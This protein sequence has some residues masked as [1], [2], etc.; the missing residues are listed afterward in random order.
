MRPVSE[1]HVLCRIVARDVELQR[2]RKRQGIDVC[3]LVGQVDPIAHLHVAALEGDVLLHRPHEVAH[4]SCQSKNLFDRIHQQVGCSAQR[5]C[6]FGVRSQ[7]LH[8]GRHRIRRG[9]MAR[10]RHDDVVP[11]QFGV[12]QRT[13]IDLAVRERT[14]QI[15]PRVRTTICGQRAEILE[16]VAY[17]RV[18]H[19]GRGRGA[20]QIGILFAEQFLCQSQHSRVVVARQTQHV[21]NHFERIRQRDLP[22]EV[23]LATQIRELVQRRD[24][25]FLQSRVETSQT[26]RFEEIRCKTSVG[27]VLLSIHVNERLHFALNL[28]FAF[29]RAE[30]RPRSIGKNLRIAFHGHHCVVSDHRPKRRVAG[31]L[32]AVH[33]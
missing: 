2:I 19:L 4:R 3:R 20:T 32:D 16:E 30:N 23:A 7:Q 9:V 33:G 11:H 25:Q 22:D 5:A 27:T 29:D 18:A 8:S 1:S 15:V 31:R 17:H 21:E 28:R 6:C 12:T 26:S 24:A 10:R 14:R 13:P